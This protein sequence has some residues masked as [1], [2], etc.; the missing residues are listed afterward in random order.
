[1]DMWGCVGFYP[2]DEN[3]LNVLL[4]GEA[5]GPAWRQP[6]LVRRFKLRGKEGKMGLTYWKRGDC[7]E[8]KK[9]KLVWGANHTMSNFSSVSKEIAVGSQH[10]TSD[11][12]HLGRPTDQLIKK[13]APHVKRRKRRKS[14]GDIGN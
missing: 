4:P 8:K 14:G 6:P 11:S 10:A 3:G 1:L 9:T 13:T 2:F 7:H 12:R 5:T